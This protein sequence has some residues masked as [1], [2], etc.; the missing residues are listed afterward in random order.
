MVDRAHISEGGVMARC[1]A[2][3][4]IVIILVCLVTG[5]CAYRSAITFPSPD[6]VFVTTGD[7]DAFLQKPYTPVGELIYIKEGFRIP[8]PILGLIPIGD[9]DPESILRGEILSKVRS[10]GGDALVSLKI[11]WTPPKA[12]CLGYMARPAL[13]VLQ[14]TVIKR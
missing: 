11:F 13:L 6:E 10:M 12:G 8:L 3:P 7:G 5:G 1:K 9:P 2:V 4:F 14:G